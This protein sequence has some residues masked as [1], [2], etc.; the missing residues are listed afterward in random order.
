MWPLYLFP[1]KILKPEGEDGEDNDQV[2]E[3]AC[4]SGDDMKMV[5]SISCEHLSSHGKYHLAVLPREQLIDVSCFAIF[6]L[7]RIFT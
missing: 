3:K 5:K 7:S 6:L 2:R 4:G 1:S